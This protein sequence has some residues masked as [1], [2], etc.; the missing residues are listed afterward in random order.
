MWQ[1]QYNITYQY[2]IVLCGNVEILLLIDK[3]YVSILLYLNE[4]GV[5]NYCQPV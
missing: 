5:A 2:N 1:Y 4:T 3:Q